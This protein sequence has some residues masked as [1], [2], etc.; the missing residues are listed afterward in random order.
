MSLEIV[1]RTKWNARPP[2]NIQLIN[3]SVPLVFIHHSYSPSACFTEEQCIKAMQSMQRFHQLE[4][5]WD[6]IGYK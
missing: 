4:R 6:D 3:K 2:K 1:S 5:G